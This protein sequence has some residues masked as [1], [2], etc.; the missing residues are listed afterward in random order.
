MMAKCGDGYTLRCY[1]CGKAFWTRLASA[2]C[3]ACRKAKA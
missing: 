3:W 1:I 2:Y